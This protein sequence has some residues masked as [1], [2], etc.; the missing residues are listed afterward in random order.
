MPPQRRPS[1]IA[2]EVAPN[3]RGTVLSETV[4]RGRPIAPGFAEGQ[5]LIQGAEPYAVP[6]YRIR[7][8]AV[9]AEIDRLRRSLQQAEEDITRLQ[10]WV[11]AEL[12]ESEAGIFAAHLAFLKDPQFLE[13]VH[14]YLQRNLVN[15][16]QAVAATVTELA[17]ELAAADNEYLRERAEDIR[18]LGRRV[19][20]HLLR[21]GSVLREIPAGAVLVTRE[22]LASDLVGMEPGRLFAVITEVG[23]EAGHGA[24]LARSLGVPTITGVSEATRR[25]P[26]EACVLVDGEIGEVLV[27]PT[28][29]ERAAFRARRHHYEEQ[30]EAAARAADG[31]ATTDGIRV[32]LFANIRWPSEAAQVVDLH[33]DGVGLFR[34]EF[35]FLDELEPPGIDR[36]RA[37]YAKAARLVQGRPLVIRTVDLGGEKHPAFLA[38]HF[39]ANPN[40]GMR[41]LRFCL[42][43][44]PELFRVQ[45]RAILEA[46]DGHDV[47]ILFPMVLGGGD[48]DQALELLREVALEAGIARLPPIGALI[49]TP[50]AVF[51][52]EDILERVDFI[53]IGTND[54]T[55]FMLAA[56][57]NALDLIGDYTVLHPA[58]LRAI[59]HTRNAAAAAGKTVSV[60]GEAASEPAIARLLVGLGIR[61]LSMSPVLAERVRRTLRASSCSELEALAARALACASPETVRALLGVEGGAV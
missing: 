23:G 2:F 45:L 12:G 53:G 11:A 16:E 9:E 50:S 24:I 41:G 51:A 6:R 58:V 13:R 55:Q 42:T 60:C 22:L 38:R 1:G 21:Q 33:L 56:D 20:R 43:V 4:L 48:L 47:R 46:G 52:I 35:M 61:E 25:I 30:D 57:R 17:T 3:W 40:L 31:C 37:A 19:L 7:P 28:E 39:E 26:N 59:R 27:A 34:T 32:G 44:A 15:A 18:D 5:A 36:Q 10:H 29:A 49:E 8:D 14:A 54:L